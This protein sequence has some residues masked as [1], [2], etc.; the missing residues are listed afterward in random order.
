[1]AKKFRIYQLLVEAGL[2][3]SKK[4]A[5]E[6]ARTGKITVDGN[7][8]ESLHYQI[9]PKK[10][11]LLVNNK[12]VEIILEQN[13]FMINKPK[14]IETTKENILKLMEQKK[15]ISQKILPTMYPIGRL[16]K[17]TTGLLIVTNDRK[18]GNKVLNPEFK[19][20][21]TYVAKINRKINDLEIDKL[22]KGVVINLEENGIIT[23]YQTKPAEINPKGEIVEVI[24][25][26][27]K[28]RQVRRMFE[29]IG[30]NVLEL[31]RV[32]IGKLHIGE[33]KEGEFKEYK[34]SDLYGFLGL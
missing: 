13:Y 4:E 22:R 33:L 23:K 6:L 24:L 26:E 1:M 9:N 20:K 18:L 25:S 12:E 14:G 17:E 32:A 19:L 7:K 3:K 30:C 21:K 31:K 5:V 29:A 8:I 28:K 16:D 15:I 11:K 27:G 2:I 10:K 34:K